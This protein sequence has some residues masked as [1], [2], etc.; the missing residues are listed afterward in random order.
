MT[1]PVVTPLERRSAVDE[2][3]AVLRDRI[4]D[5]ELP[6]GVR[7]PEQELC[8]AYAVARHTARAALRALAAEGLVVLEPHRGA[9]VAALGPEEIAGLFELRTA[10]ELEAARLALLR[11]DGRLPREVHAALGRLVAVCRRRRPAWGAVV[12]THE[13]LHAA[14]V[15]ASQSPRIVA[16]HAALGAEMRLFLVQLR[17]TWTLERMAADHERLIADLERQG[18]EVLR[19]HLRE[20]ADAVLAHLAGGA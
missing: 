4:L 10:L 15:G 18:A 11:H 9:R 6:G 8:A 13:A 5:G 1:G 16:A 2:L 3:A 17:P 20:S 14:L 7:L 12:D 19:A